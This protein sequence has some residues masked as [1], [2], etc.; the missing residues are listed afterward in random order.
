MPEDVDQIYELYAHPDITLYMEPLF[1]N[2]EEE[3]EY[4]VSY[5][6]HVY[7]FFGYG[8]WL[9]TLKDGTII[10]RAGLEH[11]EKEE[12]VAGYMLAKEYQKCG[13]ALE[14]MKAILEYAREELDIH[15][16]IAYIQIENIDS[17][18]LAEKLGLT[19]K[20]IQT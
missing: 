6:D 13:Y 11:N 1:E 20:D 12:V 8:M 17:L 7:C 19:I 9:I 5:Y 4:M 15:Q 2:R 18:R 16:V 10:G 14:A 3:K